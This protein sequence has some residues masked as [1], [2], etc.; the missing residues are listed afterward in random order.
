MSIPP[1]PRAWRPLLAAE[2]TQPYFEKLAAFLSAE[3]ARATVYPPEEL[4]FA[5]LALTPPEGT[6]VLLLGQDPYHNAGQA[7]GLSFSVRRG[8]KLPPSL[9]NI[10]TELVDDVGVPFPT[11]GDLTPW[12][13]Q[14]VLLLNAVLTVRA[15]EANSHQG[16]G[17]EIFTDRI[18]Q[19]L[20]ARPEPMVFVLWGG[21]AR[22]KARLIDASRHVLVTSAHP[23]PLSARRGFFGS[24]PFSQINRALRS[25]GAP[26]I[27]WAIPA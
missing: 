18:I 20:A 2:T 10:F 7:M 23:S 13:A 25:W 17:W 15:H 9:V 26:E 3:R 19:Q 11:N 16:H 22:R 21:Y 24:R 27:N 14:G 5:A 8:V 4:T 6:R 12:G 1:I